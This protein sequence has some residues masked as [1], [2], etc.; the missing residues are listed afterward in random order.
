MKSI[1]YN[2]YDNN[3]F[4]EQKSLSVETFNEVNNKL[5][6]NYYLINS[7]HKLSDNV[8][9][10]EIMVSD[11][12]PQQAN[13]FKRI[14][15]ENLM[16]ERT[17]IV[18]VQ[19][20]AY[21]NADISKSLEMIGDV[22]EALG[23]SFLGLEL[24]M[25]QKLKQEYGNSVKL[26][27]YADRLLSLV[28]GLYNKDITEMK[29]DDKFIRGVLLEQSN[30]QDS[31][32]EISQSISAKNGKLS[33]I[34]S[35]LDY[36][37]KSL[38]SLSSKIEKNQKEILE[39]E[40]AI[41]DADDVRVKSLKAKF[42]SFDNAK[43]KFFE[44]FGIKGLEDS[45]FLQKEKKF[46]ELSQAFKNTKDLNEQIIDR[47][48]EINGEYKNKITELKSSMENNRNE[49]E[50]M[51]SYV[52]ERKKE[53]DEINKH[54]FVRN[55]DNDISG[56]TVR[57]VSHIANDNLMFIHVTP[58]YQPLENSP[59]NQEVSAAERLLAIRAFNPSL[60]TST[61]NLNNSSFENKTFGGSPIGVVLSK[62]IVGTIKN[63]D[64][65]TIVKADGQR[66]QGSD[67]DKF[68]EELSIAKN[69]KNQGQEYNEATVHN[70]VPYA[71]VII[72]DRLFAEKKETY[73]IDGNLG[74]PNSAS[75]E[76]YKQIEQVHELGSK[77]G[78][79]PLPTI[80]MINGKMLE[81]T[82]VKP[83]FHNNQEKRNLNPSEMESLIRSQF[84]V[85]EIKS[86][87][88]ISAVDDVIP[89]GVREKV[90]QSM[91]GKYKSSVADVMKTQLEQKHG[92][93]PK[94]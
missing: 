65:G 27:P 6:S 46:P 43:I 88:E 36:H 41:K 26:S 69:R 21:Q 57:S 1:K 91:Y 68:Q 62:G 40:S 12:I 86:I 74:V 60:S 53:R 42:N 58:K 76:L 3:G 87:N 33:Q 9:A 28:S 44:F 2:T 22:P 61:F 4:V 5:A 24:L 13:I 14:E 25:V 71:N 37:Q 89:D 56:L 72:M 78:L 77:H 51:L 54:V 55:L 66:D 17:Q 32:R 30:R 92:I 18:D 70:S 45:I 11:T 67:N 80:F 35:E 94:M 83:E 73:Y 39:S 52:E 90:A 20:F 84:A 19:K 59:L 79:S 50:Y 81:V 31:L 75:K 15:Q 23:K 34:D 29:I 16:G 63:S 82:D 10:S 85:K 48:K 49:K 64:A 8:R 93:S 38:L 7:L 47:L